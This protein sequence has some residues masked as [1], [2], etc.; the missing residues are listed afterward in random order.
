MYYK[1][2]EPFRYTFG[3]PV[4]AF[5]EIIKADEEASYSTFSMLSEYIRRRARFPYSLQSSH[6]L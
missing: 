4:K 6:R 3:E 1:R 2:N 5:I